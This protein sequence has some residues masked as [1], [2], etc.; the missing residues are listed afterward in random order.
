MTADQK[1]DYVHDFEAYAGAPAASG[2][3]PISPE[4]L[5]AAAVEFRVLRQ[6]RWEAA[7]MLE[8]AQS[9]YIPGCGD[10]EQ[11]KR[12]RDALVEKLKEGT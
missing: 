7:D 11:W 8:H 3:V 12:E 5:R 2:F 1:R 6:L 10:D 4:T 9:G